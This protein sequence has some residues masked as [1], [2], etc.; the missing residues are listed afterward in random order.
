MSRWRIL[1]ELAKGEPLPATV[2]ARRVR[3]SRNGASKQLVEL[4]KAG[5]LERTYGNLYRIPAHFFVSGEPALDFGAF[6][7]R[8]DYPDPRRK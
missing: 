1:V 2:I 6:V 3:V 8:L 4:H 5:V 7:L